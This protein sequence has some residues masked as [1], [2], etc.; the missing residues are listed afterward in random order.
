MVERFHEP[1]V[2]DG[3]IY[4]KVQQPTRAEHIIKRPV[5][6]PTADLLFSLSSRSENVEISWIIASQPTSY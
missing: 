4:H 1:Y 5:K 3:S 6:T 2:T